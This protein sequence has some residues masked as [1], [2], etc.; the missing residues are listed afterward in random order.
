MHSNSEQKLNLIIQ[1]F[2]R[3]VV[4][5][6][7]MKYSLISALMICIAYITNAQSHT[8]F[9]FRDVH[10]QQ[11][12]P[13][14]TIVASGQS[15]AIA[16]D[17][18]S[19][20]LTLKTQKYRFTFSSVGYENKELSINIKRDTTIYIDMNPTEQSLE[21]V[22]I[23]S[24]TRS[25]ESIENAPIK[26]EV[27]G[28]EDMDEESAVKPAS[29]YSILGDVSGVQVVQSSATSGNMNVQIQGL[30]GQYTQIIKDG[31]P[32]YE[33]FSGNFGILSIPPLDL[34][35][36]ELI[37]GSASTLYGGGAIGGLINLI[38][39]TPSTIQNATVVL[40]RTSLN[41]TDIN[42][43]ASKRNNH[44][45]YTIYS[46]YAHQKEMDVNKDGFSDLPFLNSF[47]FHPRL[48]FYLNKTTITAGYNGTFE[49]RNGGD[50]L[51]LKGNG[52]GL[53]QYFENNHTGRHTGELLIEHDVNSYTKLYFKNCGSWFSNQFTS[54]TLNYLG[55]Q[56]NYYSELSTLINYGKNSFVGGANV[57]GNTLRMTAA[58]EFIPTN[59]LQNNTVGFFA[60]NTWQIKSNTTLEIGI[61]DDI[62]DKYGN[63]LLPRIA[64]FNRFNDHWAMRLG[65]GFGYKTPDP[66]A[67]WYID[68]DPDKIA[69]LPS[70]IQSEKSIGYNAEVNY[71]KDFGDGNTV[72][73]NQAFFLTQ[74]NHPIVG[75]INNNEN[76]SYENASKPVVSK[77]FDT[78]I[79][80]TVDDWE[81]YAGY[82]FTIVQR[83]YLR[84]NNE[85][86]YTPKNRL[87]F[88]IVKDFDAI[89]FTG[90]IEGSYNGKQY[91]LDRT[92]T[93]GYMFMAVMLS[94]GLG[95]HFTLV[96]NCENLLDYKQ[97]KA[98]A[99]YTGS[100][101]DPQFVP[102]WA[103]IDGRVVNV[104]LKYKL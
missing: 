48:F 10:S 17:S 94:K 67:S 89:D 63:F 35:Q 99:L 38:S 49:K 4:K 73:I 11:S 26:V 25:N 1:I 43:F 19:A 37:K 24:T 5:F 33:G 74:V 55:R 44:F 21:D 50:M 53:H 18:G 47:N 70:N 72:F 30:G 103:P 79:K 78:Y 22:V 100:V 7:I 31:I 69:A 29:I 57:T 83:N 102:L 75:A 60:Q 64:F 15:V 32:L 36:I 91:R 28:K 56:L 81:L 80:A 8:T 40:N 76:L 85:M 104:S 97:S 27:L 71:K 84:T 23:I 39:R 46:G 6:C 93:P 58:N 14:V 68:F 51:V 101:N 59:S 3:I 42:A 54:N 9:H 77:G 20:T 88:T 82:T 12:I 98:E 87:A 34:R 45:G 92:R 62:H 96:L 61:R 13:K 16:N 95:H 86:P 65:I 52:G 2:F 90:G 66:Y 41:E